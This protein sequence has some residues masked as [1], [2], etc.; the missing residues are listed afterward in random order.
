MNKATTECKTTLLM[1]KSKLYWQF[2]CD[3]IWLTLENIKEQKIVI[4]EIETSLFGYTYRLG[5]FLIREFDKTI[6]LR[7]GCPA[8]GPCRYSLIDKTTGKKID[9]FGQLICIDTELSDGEKYP[10]DFVVYPDSSGKNLIVQYID[11]KKKLIVP[12]S[13]QKNN[14]TARIPE[15][16]FHQMKLKNNLLTISYTT[17]TGKHLKLKI[18]LHHKKY[19]LSSHKPSGVLTFKSKTTKMT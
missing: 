5:L 17:T 2:N 15:Y 9:E 19:S 10:F 8:N 14:L 4:D 7:G 18:N 3:R 11:T 12:F 1:N 13:L 6:L 16:Q